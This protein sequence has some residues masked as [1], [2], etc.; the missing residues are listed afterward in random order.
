MDQSEHFKLPMCKQTQMNWDNSG[1]LPRWSL[2][3]VSSFFKFRAWDHHQYDRLLIMNSTSCSEFTKRWTPI[4]DHQG[5]WMELS[6]VIWVWLD[7]LAIWNVLIGQIWIRSR[8]LFWLIS[9]V[10]PS[11]RIVGSVTSINEAWSNA[12]YFF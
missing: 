11:L 9:I 8:I 10:R 2:T 1:H 5:R 7:T 4:R 12:P 3:R 6:Q